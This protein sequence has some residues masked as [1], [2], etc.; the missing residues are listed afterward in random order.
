MSVDGLESPFGHEQCSRLGHVAHALRLGA[1]DSGHFGGMDHGE[2]RGTGHMNLLRRGILG[3]RFVIASG[4]LCKIVDHCLAIPAHQLGQELQL[5]LPDR[6]AGQV[7]GGANRP[8]P[9]H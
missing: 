5:G 8:E 9:R 6:D 7:D 2:A 1:D 3:L 4:V